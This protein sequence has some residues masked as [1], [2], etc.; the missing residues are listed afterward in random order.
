[1]FITDSRERYYMKEIAQLLLGKSSEVLMAAAGGISVR[2]IDLGEIK[3]RI[4]GASSDETRLMRAIDRMIHGRALER[5]G[6]S[7][8]TTAESDAFFREVMAA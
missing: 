7:W 1:M 6:F 4:A 8:K 3:R 2:T 5:S